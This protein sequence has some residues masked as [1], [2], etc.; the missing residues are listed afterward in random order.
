MIISSCH[1]LPVPGA[2]TPSLGV[3]TPRGERS[4]LFFFSVCVLQL[5]VVFLAPSSL[6]SVPRA[7]RC[8]PPIALPPLTRLRTSAIVVHC[9]P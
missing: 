1:I 8:L 5:A 4:L 6:G 9:R 3:V 2:V 7:V